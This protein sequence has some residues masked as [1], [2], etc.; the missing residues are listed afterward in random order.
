MDKRLRLRIRKVPF[1]LMQRDKLQTTR[2]KDIAVR[3]DLRGTLTQDDVVNQF[4]AQQ[5]GKDTKRISA[6]RRIID[7]AERRGVDGHA[8]LREVIIA[9]RVHPHNG[10]HTTQGRK[11]LRGT[12]ADRPVT[13]HI[14]ARQFIRVRQL[15]M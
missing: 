7:R 13:L 9:D 10:K 4:E 15:F 5:R 2:G 3:Q 8:R 14:Q 6:Q 1:C 11:L 12:H